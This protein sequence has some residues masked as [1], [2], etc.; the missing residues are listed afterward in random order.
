MEKSSTFFERRND[1]RYKVNEGAYA[2][3][4]P[5][6]TKMGQII[7][8]SRGGLSFRYIVHMEQPID[9][10]ETHIF[11]GDKG[12]YLEKMPYI[13]VDDVQVDNTNSF[14][15]IIMRERRIKFGELN[16]NQIAQLEYFLMNRTTKAT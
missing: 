6:S 7:D 12:I 2:A 8:I 15:S 1:T 3:L 9:P 13:T 4:S 14:S 16:K 11:V 10:V 5:E